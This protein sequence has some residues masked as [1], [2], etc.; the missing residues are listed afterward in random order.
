MLAD[1]VGS[2]GMLWRVA[3]D[4]DGFWELSGS[5]NL[6]SPCRAYG[7]SI[8][9]VM[10]YCD[11]LGKS[12]ILVETLEVRGVGRAQRGQATDPR[13]HSQA[14]ACDLFT[15]DSNHLLDTSCGCMHCLAYLGSHDNLV[16]TISLTLLT[17]GKTEAERS[18]VIHPR[19]H[20]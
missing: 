16:R 7:K 13:S 6:R 9:E 15:S 11:R 4:I 5:L 14:K 20:R 10:T 8:K 18:Q 12:S 2:K 19:S 17:G 1:A 3:G